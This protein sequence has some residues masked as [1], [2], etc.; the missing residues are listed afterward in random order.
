MA[1]PLVFTRWRDTHTDIWDNFINYRVSLYD[2]I[3]GLM[4]RGVEREKQLISNLM[5]ATAMCRVHYMRVPEPIPDTPEGM[6][7]YHKKYY[8]TILGKTDVRKSTKIFKE[9]F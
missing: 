6:A 4:A 8:N 9:I 7:E 1:L 2:K 5:Y 3:E